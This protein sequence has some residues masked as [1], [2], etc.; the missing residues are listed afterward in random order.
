MTVGMSNLD[1]LPIIFLIRYT[2]ERQDKYKVNVLYSTP[3]CYLKA[4]HE[5]NR[6][7]PTKSDDFFPYA[8]DPYSYWTGYYTSRPNSKRFERIGN[9]FLQISKQ[10]SAAALVP[11]SFYSDSLVRFKSIMGVMQHHDAITGTEKQHVADDYHRE[12]YA[13]MSDSHNNVRSSLNQFITGDDP[14]NKTGDWKLSFHSCL[15]LNISACDVPE[16]S[17]KFIVTVYNPLAHKTSQ[18]VRIPVAGDNYDVK[19]ASNSNVNVQIVPIARSVLD[20]HY[21]VSKALN[22]VVFRAENVPALGYKAFYVNRLT[23]PAP[24]LL[25]QTRLAEGDTIVGG[26]DFKLTFGANGL[27][28]EITI[29]GET[30]MLSQ[31]FEFYHG[32]L[33]NN[34]IFA[35]RSSGAYIFRPDPAEELEPVGQVSTIEVFRGAHV[36]EV[37]Q[38][39]NS[40]I[41]QVVRVYK[42]ERYVELDWLVGPIDVA[43]GVGKEIVSRFYT[44]IDTNG[45]FFTD[46]NGRQMLRRRRDARDTWDLHMEEPVAGNYYPIT[47][48]IAIEDASHRLAVL[49]DRAQGGSSMV[50][51]TIELMVKLPKIL[52]MI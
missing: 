51:G 4:L 26:D 14:R 22:E 10:L 39:F 21:R 7:W 40:W 37:H 33:N 28:R 24:T 42:T 29:D 31:N 2:N 52:E 15:N 48:K 34:E 41:S 30:S 5:A 43:D 20:L 13:S 45:V 38:V 8:S 36:D 6:Q 46:A 35:N 23:A 17:A 19:D 44:D 50:D 49:N 3:S 25:R 16:N 32:A 18:Y 1:K 27:L 47:T 9:H 11:E 12:I